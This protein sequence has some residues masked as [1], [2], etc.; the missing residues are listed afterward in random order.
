MIQNKFRVQ[1]LLHTYYADI[2][3]F[4]RTVKETSNYIWRTKNDRA[5]IERED[6]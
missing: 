5:G 6:C 1:N 3:K 2:L 4:N